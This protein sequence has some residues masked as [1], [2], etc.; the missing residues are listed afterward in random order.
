MP[1]IPA[2]NEV[3]RQTFDEE[4]KRPE[5]PEERHYMILFP[6]DY[7]GHGSDIEG[8]VALL[9]DKEQAKEIR[10][11]ANEIIDALE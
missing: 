10:D 9:V 5:N 8:N 1:Y 7:D 3:R 6:E 11:L 2:L 4:P